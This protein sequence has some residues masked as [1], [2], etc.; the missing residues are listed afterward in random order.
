MA[1]VRK[2]LQLMAEK[3]GVWW[4]VKRDVI[5]RSMGITGP[6]DYSEY[7]YNRW[8]RMDEYGFNDS[9]QRRAFYDSFV[10]TCGGLG[11]L[12]L[13]P[14][15]SFLISAL[16]MVIVRI[17][18][19][20]FQHLYALVFWLAVFYYLAYLLDTPAYDFRYFYPSFFL[21]MILNASI[22]WNGIRAFWQRIRQ[23]KEAAA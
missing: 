23:G 16:M 18:R 6:L 10:V 9:R 17:R 1:A 3:P 13:R 19:S 4:S 12:T 2:Y 5:L 7:D 14:W 21:L 22:L 20:R 11:F 8:D 15:V